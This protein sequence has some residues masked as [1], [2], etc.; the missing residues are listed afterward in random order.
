MINKLEAVFSVPTMV[1]YLYKVNY[2]KCV[3]ENGFLKLAMWEN[4]DTLEISWNF[5]SKHFIFVGT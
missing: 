2:F 5:T 1:N 3:G 4:M